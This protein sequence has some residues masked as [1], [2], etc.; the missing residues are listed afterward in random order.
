MATVF[1]PCESEDWWEDK[2]LFLLLMSLR[3]VDELGHLI[4][5]HTRA[6]E[7][8]VLSHLLARLGGLHAFLVNFCSPD[9][10]AV[11]CAKTL[12][13]IAKSA[14]CLDERVPATGI[15][16][17]QGQEG[18]YFFGILAVKS[19]GSNVHVHVI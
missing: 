5:A 14:S 13:F 16:F 18:S 17:L 15:P 6:G 1:L 10:Q 11:F 4:A 8:R 3:S 19:R 9:E 7:Q 12:P 2:K